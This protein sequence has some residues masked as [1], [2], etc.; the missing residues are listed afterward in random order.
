MKSLPSSA[1]LKCYMYFLLKTFRSAIHLELVLVCGKRSRPIWLSKQ[2]GNI[3]GDDW[4]KDDDDD[5]DDNGEYQ[6]LTSYFVVV[7][8]NY[9]KMTF[10]RNQDSDMGE[11]VNGQKLILAK[12]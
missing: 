12:V 8:L 5:D 9:S 2:F 7:L 6:I 4:F 10:I 1:F 11:V 3:Y